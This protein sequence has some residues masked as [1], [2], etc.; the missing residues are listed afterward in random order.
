MKQS[1][2]ICGQNNKNDYCRQ[3]FAKRTK[4]KIFGE[5]HK[6]IRCAN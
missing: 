6:S 3:I 4:A 5:I 2:T 1:W